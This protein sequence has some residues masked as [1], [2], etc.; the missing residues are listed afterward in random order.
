M[1]IEGSG[2]VL[3]HFL[4]I[5]YKL[6]LKDC[7]YMPSIGL[8][9]IST[10]KLKSYSL[11][12]PNKVL[13]FQNN[14]LL[15]IGEQVKGLYY[16]LA[17]VVNQAL[18]TQTTKRKTEEASKQASKR[19]KTTEDIQSLIKQAEQALFQAKTLEKALQKAAGF[20]SHN[21]SQQNKAQKEAKK[22]KKATLSLWHQRMGHISEKAVRY[23]LKDIYSEE[24]TP[25]HPIGALEE[26]FTKCEPCKKATFTNKVN[27]ESR[28]STKEYS[29]LEKVTSDVCGPIKPRTYNRFRYF[30]T[31]LD[32]ATRYLEIALL[33]TKDKVYSAFIEYKNRAENNPD[34]FK[35]RIFAS[36]NGREYINK[37]FQDLFKEE[38]ITH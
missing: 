14:N 37:H 34:K 16:L 31:F 29:Y 4:D 10:S 8:N 22:A 19:R 18:V 33:R 23:L 27:K 17:Q 26:H 9:L 15:T 36:D 5:G 11:I 20:N 12:T 38:G 35:I 32:T 6:P 25:N 2:T 1:K 3:V 28:N 21:I 7:L 13:M 30:V 24:L